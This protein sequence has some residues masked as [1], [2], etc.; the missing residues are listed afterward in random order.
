MVKALAARELPEFLPPQ[1]VKLVAKPPV[2]DEWVHDLKIDGYYVQIHVRDGSVTIYS[3]DGHVWNHRYLYIMDAVKELKLKDAVIVGQAA[4]FNESH[5]ISFSTLLTALRDRQ[6]DIICYFYDVL[7]YDGEDLRNRP[8][9]ERKEILKEKILPK[10]TER[11]LYCESFRVAGDELLKRVREMDLEG[12]VSRREN[13][14]YPGD[15]RKVKCHNRQSAIICGYQKT[16][17]GLRL[18]MGVYD[19]NKDT[20]NDELTYACTLTNF[21]ERD[22]KK[23]L[24]Q[25]ERLHTDQSP[26]RN[27]KELDHRHIQWVHPELVIQVQFLQWTANGRM[28]EAVYIGQRNDRPAR[29]IRREKPEDLALK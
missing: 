1:N 29:D 4:A 25:L 16:R 19:S 9:K 15:I 20:E 11:L 8:F 13:D 27:F 28:R 6:T 23:L 10:N 14:P 17:S 18:T 7:S 2:G 21:A 24:P 26:L 5:K 12:I 22:I 3:R